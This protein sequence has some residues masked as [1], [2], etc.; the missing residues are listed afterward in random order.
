MAGFLRPG[1]TRTAA[2]GVA[3]DAERDAAPPPPAAPPTRGGGPP[4]AARR[5]LPIFRHR[6]EILYLVER[7]AV[8]VLVGATG[9]GKTTQVPQYLAEA[10]WAAAGRGVAV[11]QP[12][13]LAAA[14]AAARVCEEAGRALGAY[15]DF[16]AR[17]EDAAA[18]AAGAAPLRFATAAALLRELMEDPLLERYSVVMVDEA[19]ERALETDLLLGL[20]KV[21]QR[22]RPALRV[23]VASATADARALAAFFARGPAAARRPPGG[24]APPLPPPA[25]PPPGAGGGAAPA[26]RAP[27][28]LSVE[29]RAHGVRLS[30]LERP[31]PD[32]LVAAVEAAA[33]IHADGLPGDILIFL[34]SAEECDAAVALLL[35]EDRRLGPRGGGAGGRGLRLAPAPLYAGLPAAAAAA[36]FDPPP[37]GARRV[38]V[39]TAVAEAAVTIGGVVYVVDCMFTRRRSFD[40]AAGLESVATA[41]VSRAAAAQR[42]GRAG[43]VR[44]GHCLRL[45]TEAAFA[46]LAPA[47]EPEAERADLAGAVL[48]LKALGVDNVLR[49]DWPAPPPPA[50]LARA[51]ETL[52]AL[53]ALGDDG[54]LAAPRGARMAELPLARPA[55]AAALLAAA[56]AGAGVEGATAVA[57]LGVASLWAPGPRAACAAAVAR[58]AVAEGDLVAY[59][60][61][62]RAWEESGRSRTWAAAAGLSHPALLRAAEVRVHLAAHLRRLGMPVD[63]ALSGL[64]AGGAAARAALVR[65]RRALAAGLFLNAARL[66]TDAEVAA[67]GGGGG[68]RVGRAEFRLARGGAA[69][70]RVHPLSVL[71]HCR[72][73]WVVFASAVAGDDGWFEMQGLLTIEPEWLPELAPHYYSAPAAR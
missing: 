55:L 17:A 73:A 3:F 12:R 60:N 2:F 72:P 69:R 10:G 8:L 66:A 20:L 57:A 62:Y 58:F 25:G 59:L 67:A 32:Y 68:A 43:R 31:A 13:A 19:H 5:A 39:A 53:G 61:V 28:L 65:V 16:S 1:D 42:A 9:A 4:A 47:D 51:L 33:A 11:A 22:R 18:G 52:H 35:E 54:R 21:V 40:P 49:F 27:A 7:H 50:A 6:E 30:Y 23:V 64:P 29:G 24:G 46:A 15:A 71:F 37:R 45:C 70:L 14:A 34:A 44:P 26:E 38:V 48:Q 63:S 41:P 56:E 36:A